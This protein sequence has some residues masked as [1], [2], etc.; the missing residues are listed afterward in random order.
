MKDDLEA[1]SEVG[2]GATVH[3]G[4]DSYPAT[5]IAAT[6]DQ[7]T[8]QDDIADKVPGYDYYSNQV[9]TYR[10]NPSGDVRVFSMRKNGRLRLVGKP[11]S[12][13]HKLVLGER[14]KHS[15]P[16]H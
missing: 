11:M 9:F 14:V 7:V 15:N 2:A 13:P 12:D 16:E 5:V 3:V 1:L 10:R 8:V 4:S 6:H